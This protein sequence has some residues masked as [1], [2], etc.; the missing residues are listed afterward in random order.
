M[1]FSLDKVWKAGGGAHPKRPH[2]P[3]CAPASGS[4]YY[5]STHKEALIFA[6]PENFFQRCARPLQLTNSRHVALVLHS[7]T[8]NYSLEVSASVTPAAW[9]AYICHFNIFSHGFSSISVYDDKGG[10]DFVIFR[11]NFLSTILRERLNSYARIYCM[12][13]QNE[14]IRFFFRY[15]FLA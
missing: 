11:H 7:L 5:N 1:A 13:T 3:S 8:P 15:S 10:T 6:L 9:T 4:R 2:P 14:I 12:Y